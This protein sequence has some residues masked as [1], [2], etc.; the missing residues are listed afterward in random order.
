[1]EKEKNKAQKM[2]AELLQHI[3]FVACETI[4]SRPFF[5]DGRTQKVR[6]CQINDDLWV[7]MTEL[8]N[9]HPRSSRVIK[10]RNTGELTSKDFLPLRS[11]GFKPSWFISRSAIIRLQDKIEEII[12]W[13]LGILCLRAVLDALTN[14][15][16]SAEAFV[17]SKEEAD[18]VYDI[19]DRR[20]KL[21]REGKKQEQL[22]QEE[23]YSESDFKDEYLKKMFSAT[24]EEIQEA[25]SA[26]EDIDELASQIVGLCMDWVKHTGNKGGDWG[27]GLVMGLTKATSYLLIALERQGKKEKGKPSI[28]EFYQA[29]LPVCLEIAKED[30]AKKEAEEREKRAKEGYN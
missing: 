2:A 12:N 7:P 14:D 24:D 27:N 1:M 20:V 13:D 10:L 28:T 23:D 18:N 29:M 3:P 5:K 26:M 22:E 21:L 19:Y 6:V 4:T 30:I 16:I 25:M 15:E 11:K 17:F 8:V 9:G